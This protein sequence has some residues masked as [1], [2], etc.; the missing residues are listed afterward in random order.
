V[1]GTNKE[2]GW[3]LLL[4]STTIIPLGTRGTAE[5]KMVSFAWCDLFPDGR[6]VEK[7]ASALKTEARFLLPRLPA[8]AAEAARGWT[9]KD[10][11]AGQVYRYRLLP[12]ASGGQCVLEAIREGPVDAACGFAI[13]TAITWGSERGFPEAMQAEASYADGRRERGT[14]KLA[15]V[16]GHDLAWCREL[17]AD[18]E[19]YFAAEASY[20]DTLARPGGPA[21]VKA[22][23]EKAVADLKAAR[24]G[25]E[26]PEFRERVDAMLA[27]HE[28][29]A[30]AIVEM[31]ER[32]AALLGKPAPEWSTT[33]LEGKP[34]AL[35]DY[36]GK[37]VLM[38]F[39]YRQCY[40]CVQAM[41]QVKEVAAHFKDQPVVVLGMNIDAKEEDARA[42]V[43]QMGLNYT[44]LKA[45]GLPE[46]YKVQA[47]PTLVVIDPEGVVR[48]LLVGYSPTLKEE[49][50]RSVQRLL[51]TRP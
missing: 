38:D 12:P 48:D 11:R 17:A 36:R 49:V 27:E 47:Y 46:K 9:T 51:K 39:W 6:L 2:G 14:T 8:D 18:A 1:V 22:A 40:W 20:R 50:V 42:V 44:N 19:R 33:D 28:Q 32:R 24:R 45:A 34:H 16:K 30:Q 43:K 31:A 15:E 41:P 21:E 13:K 35:K 23:V 5:Q 29:Q 3:R 25:L 7:D 26:R 4:R 10:E 37:V